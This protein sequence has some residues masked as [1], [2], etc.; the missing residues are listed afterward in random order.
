MRGTH[1]ALVQQLTG[2]LYLFLVCLI[3]AVN[4]LTHNEFKKS[5]IHQF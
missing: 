2:C 3:Q 5:K 1:A 4:Q